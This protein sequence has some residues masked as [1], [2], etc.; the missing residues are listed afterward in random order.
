MEHPEIKDG[1]ILL[2]NVKK[3]EPLNNIFAKNKT[4]EYIRLGDTAYKTNSTDIVPE[5][6]PLFGKL[7]QNLKT[8]EQLQEFVKNNARFVELENFS[9]F[10]DQKML[11]ESDAS[12]LLDNL[13]GVIQSDLIKK[14]KPIQTL[15]MVLEEYDSGQENINKAIEELV[16]ESSK[17]ID[18]LLGK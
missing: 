13:L 17:N 5:M 14:I 16:K 11:W 6:S 15:L 2:M 8:P 7:K 18:S 12:K 10:S 4:F 9:I 1:E 3:G